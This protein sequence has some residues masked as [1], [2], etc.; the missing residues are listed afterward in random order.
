MNH[1]IEKIKNLMVEATSPNFFNRIEIFREHLRCGLIE[2]YEDYKILQKIE[3]KL[4]YQLSIT[5]Y[6]KEIKELTDYLNQHCAGMENI[7][8]KY[9]SILKLYQ[10]LVDTTTHIPRDPT[11]IY[12]NKRKID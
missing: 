4:R 3:E 1:H 11:E 12:D 7:R 6:E 9:N 5:Y 2:I 10:T 8:I